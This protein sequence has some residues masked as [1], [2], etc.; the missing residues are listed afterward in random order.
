M[1]VLVVCACVHMRSTCLLKRD[2]LAYWLFTLL[3]TNC[4]CCEIL[5]VH[6]ANT[7]K[8]FLAFCLPSASRHTCAHTYT[9]PPPLLTRRSFSLSLSLAYFYSGVNSSQ[10]NLIWCMWCAQDSQGFDNRLECTKR[11]SQKS[12]AGGTSSGTNDP[13]VV[14]VHV[15]LCDV[16]RGQTGRGS[17]VTNQRQGLA[18][19]MSQGAEHWVSDTV[20]SFRW[21][22]LQVVPVFLILIL[23]VPSGGAYHPY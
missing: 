1:L 8:H 11:T 7:T 21:R 6:F 19:W 20:E 16:L 3:A 12:Q 10:K 23:F 5:W 13:D 22:R 18:S 17:M 15:S 2:S 14:V 9:H 4:Y